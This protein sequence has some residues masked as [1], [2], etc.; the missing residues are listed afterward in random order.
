MRQY[1][2]KYDWQHIRMQVEERDDGRCVLCGF[3]QPTFYRVRDRL[4]YGPMAD[5]EGF[6][7]LRRFMFDQGFDHVFAVDMWQADH[8]VP[9]IK[10]GTHDLDNLRTL[11]VPCHKAETARLAARRAAERR[12]KARPLLESP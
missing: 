4:R 8:I 1:R 3:H 6:E 5:R 11:C 2:L 10:G 7:Y 9:R 12:D